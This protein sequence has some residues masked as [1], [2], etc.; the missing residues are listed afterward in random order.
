MDVTYTVV[1]W[2]TRAVRP[3]DDE[4][5]VDDPSATWAV[6]QDAKR[7]LEREFY[8]AFRMIDGDCDIEV[9]DAEVTES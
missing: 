1:V 8:R 6:S 5:N 2:L 9:K 4:D 3:D 7:E